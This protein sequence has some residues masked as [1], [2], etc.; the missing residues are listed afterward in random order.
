MIS[1]RIRSACCVSGAKRPAR[2]NSEITTILSGNIRPTRSRAGARPSAG[3]AQL[4]KYWFIMMKSV[5]WFAFCEASVIQG[6]PSS[7]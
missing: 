1:T 5:C 4:P 6:R 3:P 7:A 2:P